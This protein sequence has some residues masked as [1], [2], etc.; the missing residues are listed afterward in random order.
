MVARRRAILAS[1]FA[2]VALLTSGC[3]T[4][5]L[6]QA[7]SSYNRGELVEAEAFLDQDTIP[8]KD[9]VLY[10]MERGA[11]RQELGQYEA[12][13]ADFIAAH[14]ELERLETYSLSKGG[15]SLLVNDTVQEFVGVPCERSLLHVMTAWNH[16][17]LGDWDQAGVE[18]RRLIRSLSAERRGEYPEDAF[19][20]YLAGLCLELLNDD[21]NAA[22]QY[23]HAARIL[24][25]DGINADSATGPELVILLQT[26][27]MGE[28][29]PDPE[30]EIRHGEASLGYA[31]LL[32][33]LDQLSQTSRLLHAKSQIKKAAVRIA[34]KEGVTQI[35]NHNVDPLV[36]DLAR[37]ILIAGLERP[38]TRAWLALPSGFLVARVPCP[39]DLDEV[40]LRLPDGS[41]HSISARIH[42]AGSLR[43]ALVRI[44]PNG[45]QTAFED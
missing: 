1:T 12:S 28:Q 34:L 14:A 6:D 41:I 43:I 11:I 5:A 19:S 45:P 23:A 29:A 42:R 15:A 8:E 3:A 7:R 44:S 13:S 18:A 25:S 20:R 22:Q 26:G 36:G 39:T 38:D 35:I 40:E 24:A 10:L 16:L 4:V 31:R 33:D 9:K 17:A 27:R 32:T 37:L 2:I 30:V 21:S